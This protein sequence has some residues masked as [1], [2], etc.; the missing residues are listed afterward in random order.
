MTEEMSQS[1]SNRTREKDRVAL[2]HYHNEELR[3]K[4]ETTMLDQGIV[5]DES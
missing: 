1:L 5:F 4:G 2:Q 3:M